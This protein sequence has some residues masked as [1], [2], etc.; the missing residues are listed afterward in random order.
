MLSKSAAS[1]QPERERSI[2]LYLYI[3][4]A[5]NSIHDTHTHTYTQLM[6]L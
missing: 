4:K 3:T 5:I 1:S 2:S 6:T